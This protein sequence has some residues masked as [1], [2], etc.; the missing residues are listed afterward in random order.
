MYRA[1]TCMRAHVTARANKRQ[2]PEL[3][4]HDPLP[5]QHSGQAASV[6]ELVGHQDHGREERFTP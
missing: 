1:I 5:S 2:H 3:E 4:L 6:G